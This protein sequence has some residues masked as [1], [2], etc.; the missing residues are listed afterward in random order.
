MVSELRI[1]VNVH[2]GAT[3]SDMPILFISGSGQQPN[4]RKLWDRSYGFDFPSAKVG[5]MYRG[6]PFGE[7]DKLAAKL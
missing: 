7:L 5:R 6:T 1:T 3:D 4:D 2:A